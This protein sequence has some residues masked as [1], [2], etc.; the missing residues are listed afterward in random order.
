MVR[1]SLYHASKKAV[2]WCY[3]GCS[4]V[5][6]RYYCEIEK[7]EGLSNDA[8]YASQIS[9]LQRVEMLISGSFY[10]KCW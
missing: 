9:I 8:F 3:T 10:C 2:R 4:E 5:S 7:I 6:Y 1:N